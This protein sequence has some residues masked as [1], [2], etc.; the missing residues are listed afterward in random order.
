[1]RTN[2][3]KVRLENLS[4][5]NSLISYEE[6]ITKNGHEGKIIWLCGL[7]GSGKST[8]AKNLEAKLFAQGKK[9][10]VLD[11]DNIRKGLSSDLGFSAKD[12][13]ENI[14]RVAEV[15]KLFAQAGF[16]VIVAFISPYDKDRQI[17]RSIVGNFFYGVY[18]KAA[19]E[20]CKMRD[21]KGLYK[22][23]EKG[24]IKNF[25][26]VSDMF[27][28]PRDFDLTIDTVNDNVNYSIERIEKLIF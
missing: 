9:V 8:I 12:R 18:L 6:R 4:T 28:E 27:E 5:E 25:T 3:Q 23:A 11:G 19:V 21:P 13:S 7:S 16:I 14:R 10:F 24:E 20:I 22:K 15:A 1:M 2:L 17:A 26:G